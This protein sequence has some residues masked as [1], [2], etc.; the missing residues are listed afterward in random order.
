MIREVVSGFGGF[1]RSVAHSGGGFADFGSGF[2]DCWLMI[3][4]HN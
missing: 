4:I 1:D 2:R 3:I